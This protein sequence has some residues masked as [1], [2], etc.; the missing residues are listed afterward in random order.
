MTFARWGFPELRVSSS[1]LPL[2]QPPFHLGPTGIIPL[3]QSCWSRLKDDNPKP[4]YAAGFIES[5]IWKGP[6]AARQGALRGIYDCVTINAYQA[7]IFPL[8]VG[9]HNCSYLQSWL[10]VFLVYLRISLKSKDLIWIWAP[11]LYWVFKCYCIYCLELHWSYW[12]SYFKD[13]KSW[14]FR[15]E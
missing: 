11:T 6:S 15:K 12:W 10:F 1:T 5:H 3:S 8:H 13:E 2:F 4:V 7:L 14:G 9:P